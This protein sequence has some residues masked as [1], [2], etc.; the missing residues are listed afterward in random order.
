MKKFLL[1]ILPFL[2]LSFPQYLNQISKNVE[3]IEFLS[4]TSLNDY[5]EYRIK[6]LKKEFE[7]TL[8][9]KKNKDS[10]LL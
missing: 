2:I 7:Q 9:N 4:K 6:E 10:N 1:L 3:A 8:E 5:H